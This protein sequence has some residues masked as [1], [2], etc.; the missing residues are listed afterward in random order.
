VLGK[1][2]VCVGYRMS[3]VMFCDMAEY[4]GRVLV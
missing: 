2:N 3:V 1:G 4:E